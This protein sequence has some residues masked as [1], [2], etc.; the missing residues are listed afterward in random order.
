[1]I[2]RQSARLR[3]NETTTAVIKFF[4]KNSFVEVYVAA[5]KSS[6]V[7]IAMAAIAVKTEPGVR[8][9][10]M[11]ATKQACPNVAIKRRM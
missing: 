8:S 3:N 5:T 4:S 7:T 11:A 10:A 9:A 1:M 2:P 6:P